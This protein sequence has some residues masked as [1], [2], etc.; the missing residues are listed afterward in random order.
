MP[1]HSKKQTDRNKRRKKF[2]KHLVDFPVKLAM[3]DFNQCD[4]RKCSG[5]KL[6]RLGYIKQ[7]KLG[8]IFGG[9]ILSPKGKLILSPSDV[10]LLNRAGAA[11]IDCS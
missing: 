3:W 1:Q 2:N 11:V 6:H 5:R 7:L 8:Q 4:P 10:N 9:I